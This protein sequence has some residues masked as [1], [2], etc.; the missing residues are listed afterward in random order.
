MCPGL[1]VDT[2]QMQYADYCFAFGE[3]RFTFAFLP[4]SYF[5][6]GGKE[7][8]LG[9]NRERPGQ[10]HEHENITT[11]GMKD[12]SISGRLGDGARQ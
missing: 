7:Y 4:Y 8:E 2:A 5:C 3:E 11:G 10:E 9:Q 1:H 12:G 6:C